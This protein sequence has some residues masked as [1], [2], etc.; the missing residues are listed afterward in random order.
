MTGIYPTGTTC[1]T[2]TGAVYTASFDPWGNE[3]SRI[4]NSTTAT[5]SYDALNRLVKYSAG[6]NQE[7]YLY[8]ASGN[9]VL[10]R[11]TSG[12]STG[13]TVYAYGLQEIGYS[14]SGGFNS[15]TDYYSLAGHLIGS[16][17][18]TNTTYDLTD[19]LGSVLLSLST[20]A[21]VGEQVYGPYGNQRHIQGRL[22]TDKGYTGQ[23]HDAVTGLDYYN[24]RYY[25]PVMAQFLSADHV[26][27][28]A[29]GVDP[30][31]Y[32][33]GNPETKAD[34]TGH[35]IPRGLDG[36][37]NVS[38]A[39]V[40]AMAIALAAF[41]AAAAAANAANL[42]HAQTRG[43]STSGSSVVEYPGGIEVNPAKTSTAS[44]LKGIRDDG[45]E[46]RKKE[47]GEDN[48]KRDLTNFGGAYLQL[49]TMVNGTFVPVKGYIS[50]P[51]LAYETDYHVEDQAVD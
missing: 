32:V 36:G 42:A 43:A 44:V 17:D 15:Q 35:Y 2:L 38:A 33:G 16:T 31:A 9:R 29:Q 34:P 41:G 1:S 47:A 5:L 4:Y 11:S 46:E 20:S 48:K 12:G 24:A 8:D 21:V 37:G 23:F 25:D 51:L 40:V 26:Q 10:K 50:P 3:T 13:L 39:D 19:A 28:N 30:Y 49:G 6:S 45:K 7:F 18:G 14:A 22:G 27:G